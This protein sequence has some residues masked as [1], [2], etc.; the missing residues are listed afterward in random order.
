YQQIQRY[1]F[2]SL[3]HLQITSYS[4]SFSKT[5]KDKKLNMGFNSV[6]Q[7][8]LDIFSQVDPR[9]LR[10]VAIENSR[11]ADAAVEI[12][13]SEI[14][15]YLSKQSVAPGFS[16]TSKDSYT[17]TSKK[18]VPVVASNDHDEYNLLRRCQM[19]NEVKATSSSQVKPSAGED[20]STDITCG[21]H[22]ADLDAED[23]GNKLTGNVESEELILLGNSEESI[24]IE[25]VH[26]PNVI[27]NTF[28]CEDGEIV[29]NSPLR[30]NTE[31]KEYKL[32]DDYIEDHKNNKKIFSAAM[33]A[34][35][36]MRTKVEVYVAAAEEANKEA[37]KGRLDILDTLEELKQRL[38]REKETN[39]MHAGE[40]NGEAS[41]LAT[42]VRELQIRLLSLSDDR[43]KCLAIL[44]E[45]NQDLEVQL[46]EAEELRKSA[47]QER[48]EMEE[49]AR[50]ALAE[51]E[52][53]MEKVVLES[54][55][56]KEAAEDN[57]KLRDFLIDRGRVVDALQGE[58]SVVCQDVKLLKDKIHN[59]VPVSK[60]LSSS[61]SSGI[62]ASSHSSMKSMV[63]DLVPE[64]V[65][66]SMTPT[67]GNP[68]PSVG[69]HSLENKS[70]DE[71]NR[72]DRKEF[73]DD[74]WEFFENGI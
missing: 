72:A 1:K 55:I 73:L 12:V 69:S 26:N 5:T 9:L 56:L 14:L 39:D 17:S 44:D 40:V 45:L 60:S 20:A 11:D 47:E 58:M 61:Q 25:V 15:P 8:L 18:E 38:K 48:L 68:T 28:I 42:E 27:S 7:C 23:G 36:N 6:Y 65:E 32:L 50:S 71:T 59:R 64:P 74:G 22:L 53:I 21:T 33:E 66:N 31:G 3:S 2:F 54:K 34:I 67:K 13:L 35:E 4:F 70:E 51:Q 62:L 63:S 49:S 19:I 37:A 46:A 24:G 41:I 16:S 30:V 43:D 29:D 10:A 52:S 57:S